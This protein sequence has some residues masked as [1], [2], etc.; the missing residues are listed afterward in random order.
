VASAVHGI[1]IFNL[2]S[3]RITN[4]WLL[5][6]MTSPRHDAPHRL[7]PQRIAVSCITG[8]I[9]LAEYDNERDIA[10][11]CLE[12]ANGTED[13]DDKRACSTL[14]DAYLLLAK[15]REAEGKQ[16]KWYIEQTR[17]F[18]RRVS[19]G[20]CDRSSVALQ[21]VRQNTA[22]DA[23]RSPSFEGCAKSQCCKRERVSVGIAA[24]LGCRVAIGSFS[25]WTRAILALA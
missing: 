7:T 17:L 12:R 16:G 21:L 6:D 1:P 24:V 9:P 5:V 10:V 18:N 15:L 2:G 14:A 4:F 13:E 20:L 25:S 22:A 11:E 3:I 8:G 23:D 19:P